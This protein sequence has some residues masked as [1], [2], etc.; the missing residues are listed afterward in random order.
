MAAFSIQSC[1]AFTGVSTYTIYTFKTRIFTRVALTLI[2]IN[3]TINTCKARHTDAF[4]FRKSWSF[5]AN[6]M[7]RAIMFSACIIEEFTVNAHVGYGVHGADALVPR[8]QILTA[9]AIFTWR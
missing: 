3:A 7:G 6:H 1:L 8:F 2:N 9:P 4:I 5:V